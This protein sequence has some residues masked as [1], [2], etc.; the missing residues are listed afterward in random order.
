MYLAIV[1]DLYSR[2]IVGW[3]SAVQNRS[4]RFCQSAGRRGGQGSSAQQAGTIV[5]IHYPARGVR[6][7]AV[8][9][10]EWQ[11]SL[12]TKDTVPKRRHPR[13]LYSGPPALHPVGQPAA[14][15]NHSR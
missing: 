11:H 10:P 7:A 2:R 4:R 1:M 13:H 15:Q 9:D 8:T 5:P 12:P 14:V 3:P 6:K